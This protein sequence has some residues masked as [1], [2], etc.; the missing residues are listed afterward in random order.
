MLLVMDQSALSAL[1]PWA[2]FYVIVGSS[3]GALIG[4][5]FVV[6]TLVSQAEAIRSAREIRAFGSPTVVHF[7]AALVISAIMS[8][9]WSTLF[10]VGLCLVTLGTAGFAYAIMV[11]RHARTQTG[12]APDA[13]DWFWYVVL[14]LVGYAALIAEAVSL[15]QGFKWCLF[16]VAASSLLFLFIGIH[17]A[18]DTVTYVALRRV[19]KVNE[20]KASN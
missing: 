5:Q 19:E 20:R 13:E 14:P 8:A 6:I 18:W 1:V 4:L 9:P 16:L 7:G 2:N 3:A 12:Y 11:V 15:S 10:H 17:N